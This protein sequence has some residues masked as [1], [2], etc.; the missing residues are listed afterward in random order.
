MFDK[1][2]TSAY[3]LLSVNL[4]PESQKSFVISSQHFE[5]LC[6]YDTV[7]R[8]YREIKKFWN[9]M[10]ILIFITL[11]H[12]ILFLCDNIYVGFIENHGNN[13]YLPLL[14]YSWSL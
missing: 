12:Y 3:I 2:N 7:S 13:R 1:L 8:P 14:L 5:Y 11:V 4:V 6:A 10:M 9:L